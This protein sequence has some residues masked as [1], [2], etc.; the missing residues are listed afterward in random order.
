MSYMGYSLDSTCN[1]NLAISKWTDS[2]VMI[3]IQEGLLTN[4]QEYIHVTNL[5]VSL[6]SNSHSHDFYILGE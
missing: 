3:K 2:R 1:I 6:I 5:F 4:V